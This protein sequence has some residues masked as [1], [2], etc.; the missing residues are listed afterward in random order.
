MAKK[1][2]YVKQDLVNLLQALQA[3]ENLSGVKLAIAIK[4]NYQII[5]EALQDIEN[6]A[7]PSKE[8][9]DLAKEMQKFDMEKDMDKVK[10]E[11][12]KPENAELIE[13]RKVQLDEVNQLLQED[14]ELKLSRIT[15][16]DLPK[17]ITG[18]QLSGIELIIK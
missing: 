11:E 18:K 12:A 13:K 2:K 10:E 4:E 15:L 6:K 16:K 3:V 14:I 5:G 8:F 1:Q 9:M 17:D 7:I